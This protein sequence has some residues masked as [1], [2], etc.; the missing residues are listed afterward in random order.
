MKRKLSPEELRLWQSQLK[1]TKPLAKKDKMAP[2]PPEVRIELRPKP[3]PLQKPSRSSVSLP[4][5]LQDVGKR[6]LRRLKIDGRL[7][8]HGMTQEEAYQ[9]LERFLY[10]ART[11][12]WKFV[13]IITGKGNLSSENT[14]RSQLPRWVKETSLASLVTSLHYPAKL[15]DGG[16]GAYYLGVRKQKRDVK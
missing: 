8:M 9:A 6:E 13:L 15:Q 14:L 3:K 12:G 2:P 5:P 11:R 1:D 4:P 7:D 10:R 16:G